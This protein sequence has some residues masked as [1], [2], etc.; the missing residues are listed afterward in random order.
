MYGTWENETDPVIRGDVETLD[1]T[2]VSLRK[3]VRY[4][5]QSVCYK[6]DENNS[7][8]RAA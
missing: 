3:D 2:E 6:N 7:N 5:V 8:L 1:L 4:F